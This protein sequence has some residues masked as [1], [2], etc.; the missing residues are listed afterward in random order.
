M[1]NE[2]ILTDALRALK[3][4]GLELTP[5]SCK[6]APWFGSAAAASGAMNSEGAQMNEPA[7]TQYGGGRARPDV[8][9]PAWTLARFVPR[10]KVSSEGLFEAGLKNQQ[11]SRDQVNDSLEAV[12]TTQ[13]AATSSQ[14]HPNG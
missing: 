6:R 8:G 5:Q 11:L 10:G 13:G 9:K 2:K 3:R 12:D 7:P 1:L 14:A 4:P